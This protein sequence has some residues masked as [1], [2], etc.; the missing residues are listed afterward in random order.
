MLDIASEFPVFLRLLALKLLGTEFSILFTFCSLWMPEFQDSFWKGSPYTAQITTR[1][2][3]GEWIKTQKR[4]PGEYLLW[5]TLVLFRQY[6]HDY[7]LRVILHLYANN[8]WWIAFQQAFDRQ[9]GSA[10]SP[11]YRMF[12]PRNAAQ[13]HCDRMH[14]MQL[15]DGCGTAL[16]TWLHLVPSAKCHMP[17]N[18][19]HSREAK[20]CWYSMGIALRGSTALFEWAAKS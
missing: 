6:R 19:F 14:Y 11:P 12:Y 5:I 2:I 16:F 15:Q 1:S 20:Q 10:M 4:R 3:L 8:P 7:A 13:L 17:F 9:W 18:F